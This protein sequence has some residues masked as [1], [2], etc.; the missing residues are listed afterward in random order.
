MW[1]TLGVL[2]PFSACRIPLASFP[3]SILFPSS[4]IFVS[5][6]FPSISDKKMI[7][8]VGTWAFGERRLPSGSG[9]LMEGTSFLRAGAS[10]PL[11]LAFQK[12][13]CVPSGEEPGSDS[14]CLNAFSGHIRIE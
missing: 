3:E 12:R 1:P 8:R 2:E 5:V 14:K 6:L 11:G 9:L 13:G 7:C 10:G 4:L